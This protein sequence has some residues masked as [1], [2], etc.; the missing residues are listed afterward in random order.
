MIHNSSTVIPSLNKSELSI[1]SGYQMDWVNSSGDG[2]ALSKV[3]FNCGI[4][5]FVIYLIA[6]A[7]D[8][9]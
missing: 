2:Y 5:L 9:I 3:A 8:R 6:S 4:N 1:D 7:L